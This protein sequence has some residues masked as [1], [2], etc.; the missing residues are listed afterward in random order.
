MGKRQKVRKALTSLFFYGNDDFEF[1]NFDD[2]IKLKTQ[3]FLKQNNIYKPD[4]TTKIYIELTD[5]YKNFMPTGILGIKLNDE[6]L[7]LVDY[8][9][10]YR[11]STNSYILTLNIYNSSSVNITSDIS[12]TIAYNLYHDTR[13]E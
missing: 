4:E 1:H 6:R 7:H 11:E 9:I 3:S 13:Y 12:C 2:I 8:D 5:T 10:I